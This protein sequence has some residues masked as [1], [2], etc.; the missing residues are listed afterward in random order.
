M[1]T[2]IICIIITIIFSFILGVVSAIKYY[3]YLY[4]KTPPNLLNYGV[5]YYLLPRII[6][7][8]I[9]TP[10]YISLLTL[11]IYCINPLFIKIKQSAYNSYNY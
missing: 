11:I 8:C 3:E 7:E 4:N 5:V 2:S 1:F 10:I 6:K 9:K